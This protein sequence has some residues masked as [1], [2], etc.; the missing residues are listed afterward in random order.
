MD[1]TFTKEKETK[2]AIRFK[3]DGDAEKIGSLYLKK[4]AVSDLSK[5]NGGG[6]VTK[7]TVRVEAV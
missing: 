1:I 3:E 2:N 5:A 7:I 4:T 6:E